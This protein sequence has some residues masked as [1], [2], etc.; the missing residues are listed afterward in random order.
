MALSNR[1]KRLLKSSPA[2]SELPAYLETLD[3]GSGSSY[4]D[5]ALAARVKALE[6]LDIEARLNALEATETPQE[7]AEP[8]GE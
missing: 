5:T 1:L 7:E 3:G 2:T 4:D 6:D 8:A